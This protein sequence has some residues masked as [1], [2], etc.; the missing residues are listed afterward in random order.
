[1]QSRL[2]EG[3]LSTFEIWRVSGGL[4]RQFKLQLDNNQKR[5]LSVDS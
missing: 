5:D 4:L 3:Q 2:I 1:M